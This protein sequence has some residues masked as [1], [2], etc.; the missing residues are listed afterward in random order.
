MN[1][2]KNLPDAVDE[3]IWQD[4]KGEIVNLPIEGTNSAYH[5]YCAGLPERLKIADLVDLYRDN[6]EKLLVENGGKITD[7]A[8]YIPVTDPA[9]P[10][11]VLPVDGFESGNLDGYTTTGGVAGTETPFAG[12]YAARIAG[13][14]S[15]DG[16]IV[17]TL[18]GLTVGKTYRITAF[19]STSAGTSA[20][21]FAREA[22]KTGARAAVCDN[23]KYIKRSLTF[24]ATAATMEIGLT[25]PAGNAS[26]KSAAMDELVV[27]RVEETP[28]ATVS[29]TQSGSKVDFALQG[30]DGKE[31]LLKLTFENN[32]GKIVSA[33]ATVDGASYASVP[34]YP[35]G[36]ALASDANTVYIPVIVGANT[37]VSLDF[38]SE[39]VTVRDAAVVRVTE[40]FA[41]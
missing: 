12:S 32:A 6:F 30:G 33:K 2:M 22:G 1:G 38:G 21:L 40:R 4:G 37:T 18:T 17:K 9:T 36:A 15:R 13:N 25:Y 28:A 20:Y 24:T 7:T 8:Y 10:D 41:K 31:A 23:Q 5:M 39:T 35:T 3:K 11:T 29:M 16:E 26:H 27:V 19:V 34:F 14:E